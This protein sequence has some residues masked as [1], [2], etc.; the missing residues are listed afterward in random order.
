VPRFET[1]LN[2]PIAEWQEANPFAVL[3]PQ[4]LCL[5]TGAA[6]PIFPAF[7]ILFC[8]TP[9]FAPRNSWNLSCS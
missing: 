9:P 4:L 5:K 2:P 3:L 7:A 8:N 6:R 1:R